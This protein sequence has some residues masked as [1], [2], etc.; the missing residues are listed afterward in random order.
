ME[1][2]ELTKAS[3]D[4]V[5]L[6]RNSVRIKKHLAIDFKKAVPLIY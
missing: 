2:T 6:L 5:S 4:N 1:I 3:Q